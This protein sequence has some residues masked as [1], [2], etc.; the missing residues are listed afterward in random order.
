MTETSH[1]VPGPRHRQKHQWISDE[2]LGTIDEHRTAR[3]CGNKVL[4]RRLAAKRKQQL[5]RDE[6][7]WYSRIADKAE[8]AT[9][10]LLPYHPHSHRSDCI[11][12]T[13]CD[14]QRRNTTLR[15]NGPTGVKTI[16]K[17]S[18]TIL[19]HHSIQSS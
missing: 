15:S 9:A 7:A 6:T 13:N 18:S 8:D 11:Q 10:V 1:V 5:R 19:P 12:A 16:S 3:L 17:N 4:A 14:C 2:T